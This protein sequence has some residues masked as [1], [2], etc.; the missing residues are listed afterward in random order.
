MKM[1]RRSHLH[2]RCRSQALAEFALILPIL[3]TLICAGIDYGL[4]VYKIQTLTMLTRSGVNTAYRLYSSTS[5]LDSLARAVTNVILGAAPN[6]GTKFRNLMD[7]QK[8]G[9]VVVTAMT[10]FATSP[11]AN[12]SDTNYLFLVTPSN[13]TNSVYYDSGMYTTNIDQALNSSRLLAGTNW[14]DPRRTF[15]TNMSAQ[16]VSTN[17]VVFSC[18]IFMTNQF[19][20]PAGFLLNVTAPNL[21]YDIA[22]F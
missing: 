14:W 12:A 3:I 20:T 6:T 21:L 15:G 11:T 8:E 4:M 5:P 19:I 2:T 17:Q 16:D 1:C 7:L 9:A 18:E 13:P 22:V 10:S